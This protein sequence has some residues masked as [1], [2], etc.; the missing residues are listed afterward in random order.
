MLSLQWARF[1]Y[2]E[3]ILFSSFIWKQKQTQSALFILYTITNVRILSVF[4]RFS[5]N[6]DG[7]EA[8]V[9]IGVNIA[10][11]C[12]FNLIFH[13]ISFIYDV[14]QYNWVIEILCYSVR[15]SNEL[16]M[17]H[18]RAA[19]YSVYTTLVQSVVI[20]IVCMIVV[21]ATRNHFSII[22]TDSEDMRR[23]VAHLSG[24]LG[25]TMLLNSI[26]PVISGMLYMCF[27]KVVVKALINCIN[28]ICRC[29][30]RRRMASTGSLHQLGM[31]LCIW[32]ASRLSP[33]LCG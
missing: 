30:Y 19:R 3:L 8:M 20:G 26:Q 14:Q 31:L 21:V 15:V 17:G 4:T 24:L 2:G 7:W 33:R 11:R 28:Y 13:S 10:I 32:S 27:S 29:G 9:F 6:V 23:A 5:M 1:L 22:F 16:G 18:P 12:K 25:I